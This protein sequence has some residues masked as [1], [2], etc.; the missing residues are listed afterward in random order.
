MPRDRP[1]VLV[2]RFDAPPE[3]RLATELEQLLGN[4][5]SQTLATASGNDDYTNGHRRDCI[6]AV[7]YSRESCLT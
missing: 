6:A 4:G 3:Q 2:E 5:A 1:G 7:A